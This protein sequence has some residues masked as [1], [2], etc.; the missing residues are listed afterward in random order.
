[1]YPTHYPAYEKVVIEVYSENSKL[2]KKILEM[3]K[4]IHEQNNKMYEHKQRET[5][6]LKENEELRAE[7]AKMKD[8]KM[9]AERGGYQQRETTDKEATISKKKPANNNSNGNA[10]QSEDFDFWSMPQNDYGKKKKDFVQDST[11][12]V[13][14]KQVHDSLFLT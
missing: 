4:F 1:M 9:L 7:V 13:N 11:L 5:D 8:Q 2:K 3:T 10:P 14:E 12:W 6:L